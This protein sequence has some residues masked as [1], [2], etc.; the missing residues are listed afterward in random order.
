M[1]KSR[2]VD[3]CIE[4]IYNQVILNVNFNDIDV[5]EVDDNDDNEFWFDD[6]NP[7]IIDEMDI[8]MPE[9]DGNDLLS[10]SVKNNKKYSPFL[11]NF[12]E[13]DP[14]P[15]YNNAQFVFEPE[16]FP[17]IN[18]NMIDCELVLENMVE[19]IEIILDNKGRCLCSYC[20]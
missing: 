18:Y 4:H 15:V 14:F 3:N 11:D 5:F 16:P 17:E 2:N 12:N 6:P 1:C 19:H 9:P 13:S 20:L 8:D 7:Q 10:M